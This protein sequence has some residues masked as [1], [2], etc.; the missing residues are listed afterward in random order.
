MME[1]LG[2]LRERAVCIGST[3]RNGIIFLVFTLLTGLAEAADSAWDSSSYPPIEL[4]LSS[5]E[6]AW[7]KSHPKVYFTGDPNWL[8]YE[9]FKE[10][11]SYIGIVAD[12]LNQIE[13]YTGIEFIA[14]PVA[15]WSESL[16][17][18]MQGGVS[19]IS[20][21]AA[22]STLQ[23]Q[24]NAVRPY[25]HNPIVIIMDESQHY[26]ED[27]EQIKDRKIAIIKDYGYT[28]DIHS[29]YPDIGFIEVMN[30]QQGLNGVAEKRFDAMLATMAL[31]SYHMAEMGL[32]NI[33][34]VGKTPIVMGLTLFV[35]KQEPILHSIIDKTLKAL[36]LNTTQS[37]MQNWV[38]RE[39]VEKIDYRLLMQVLSVI[40]LLLTFTL[41]WIFRLRMEVYHRREAEVLLRASEQRYDLAM[42]V[43]NDGIWDWDIANDKVLFDRR[44]YT[45][46]GYL[47][48]E[49]EQSFKAWESRIHPEDIDRVKSD[50]QRYL[51]GIAVK[52]DVEFRFRCKHGDYMWIQG[53]GK[54]VERGEDGK[55]DRIV[56][57]H[58]D[59]SEKKAYER[60][61]EHIAHFDSLTNLPNRILLID[62]LNQAMF[63]AQRRNQKLAIAYLDLDGFKAINDENDHLIGDQFLAKIS[64]EMHDVLRKGDTLA[65]L[66]GDEFVAVLVDLPSSEE[67]LPLI[68]RLQNAAA[69]PI[70]INNQIMRVSASIGVTFYPQL[71]RVDAEQLIRQADHSMYKAKVKGKNRYQLFNVDL[72]SCVDSSHKNIN[73]AI[74]GFNKRQ[75]LMHYQPIVNLHSGEVLGFESLI[76]W[77]HPQRGILMPSYFFSLIEDT[78]VELM[79]DEWAIESV[80]GQLSEWS[81][82]YEIP[83]VSINI[84]A[85][86]L[87]QEDFKNRITALLKKYPEVTPESIVLEVNQADVLCDIKRFSEVLEACSDLGVK[88]ALDNFCSGPLMLTYL[89]QLSVNIVKIDQKFTRNLLEKTDNLAILEGITGF[90]SAFNRQVVAE[91][92]ESIEQG[93][94][95]LKMGC[96]LGQGY[97]I[98]RPMP[99]NKV[100]YWMSD[101]KPSQSWML[102][103][104]YS[105][106]DYSAL[107]ATVEHQAWISDIERYLYWDK[108]NIPEIDHGT[109]S[110]GKWLSTEG[111][112]RYGERPIFVS[113][114]RVHEE[115]HDL[116]R[117]LLRLHYKGNHSQAKAGLEKMYILRDRLSDYLNVLIF[118]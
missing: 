100:P 3:G 20:G 107:Y 14:V 93:L 86:Y 69:K 83:P 24:F 62:R 76:R 89:K 28:S 98:S 74:E 46:A 116:A 10:D 27:L 75:Y 68:K 117:H 77:Q 73:A 113:L 57:T 70:P 23:R 49:F 40:L 6:K 39:Y 97:Q 53:R 1:P 38:T 7:I 26:V 71:K 81:S 8:P 82:R 21:D 9:A 54:I 95:L 101:W 55:P 43:A 87:T 45:M 30:I 42:A 115:M 90:A 99:A 22:D 67:S 65:R 15:T 31:A 109:C 114:Q 111:N 11:G 61:L 2:G 44:Y 16:Q 18:A 66:G 56:G 88:F 5:D 94:L 105:R 78:D 103:K 72:D 110:F 118:E 112:A 80:L 33:K 96:Q 84:S 35:D 79:V 12:H 63:Q 64:S 19:V 4:T 108:D 17:I 59:I 34:V 48:Y 13:H 25:S 91:G 32:H 60:Q 41:W 36:P 29:T 106:E 104:S 85:K 58:S 47:A 52:F 92:V 102:Q 37:I 50:L 51:D